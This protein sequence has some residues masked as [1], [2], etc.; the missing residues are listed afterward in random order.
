MDSAS[1]A[2]PTAAVGLPADSPGD[3]DGGLTVVAAVLAGARDGPMV[4]AAEEQP[5]STNRSVRPSDPVR[6]QRA[7]SERAPSSP[8]PSCRVRLRIGRMFAQFAGLARWRRTC[9]DRWS[10]CSPVA[11]HNKSAH[12]SFSKRETRMPTHGSTRRTMR[13]TLMTAGSTVTAV[14][15]S[16]TV[17]LAGGGVS[18]IAKGHGEAVKAVAQAAGY[19]SG[20]AHGEA[21]SALAKQHGAIVSAAAR[22]Q[23]QAN[24]A[25][26]KAKGQQ[27]AAA[28]SAN[29]DSAS[30]SGRLKAAEHQPG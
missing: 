29:G 2:K 6:S 30:E 1:N 9:G 17:A 21:V 5:Q 19:V 26:G 23:G 24:A 15:L 14:A 27:H 7:P 8:A 3:A 13:R 10:R 12:G 25:A 11:A 22:A 16:A 28:G 4:G 20:K 18:D